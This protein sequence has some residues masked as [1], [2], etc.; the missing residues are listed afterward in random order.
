MTNYWL[1]LSARERSLI[2][3]CGA[4]IVLFLIYILIF[5]PISDAKDAAFNALEIQK[6]SYK[7]VV[8]MAT[9]ADPGATEVINASEKL[10]IRE[11]A[12][13]ASRV[14]GI[15]ISR[16]Q[17]GNDG[18][19]TFWIDEAST[20]DMTNWLLLLSNQYRWQATKVSINKNTGSSNLRGQFGFDG[21]GQ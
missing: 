15:A 6:Q 21:G 10:P 18:L 16:I 7:R 2:S 9:N 14:L 8:V 19:I 1:E 13:E 11:A 17:P 5:K 20:Q 12:T 4:T 3:I